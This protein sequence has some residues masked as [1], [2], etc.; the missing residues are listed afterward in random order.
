VA[1]RSIEAP[2]PIDVFSPAV[3]RPR[4]F[5]PWRRIALMGSI[6]VAIALASCLLVERFLERRDTLRLFAHETYGAVGGR[7][8]RFRLLGAGEPG[9]T[10]V[11][12]PGLFA[13]IEQW[14]EAQ[15]TLASF[16]PTLSYDRGGM[17]HSDPAPA[18]DA[19]GEAEELEGVLRTSGAAPPYLIVSYSSSVLAAQVFAARHPEFIK[20]LVF[21]DPMFNEGASPVPYA[22]I[23]GKN[24]I[25]MTLK[26]A[27]GYLRFQQFLENRSAPPPTLVEEKERAILASTANW[28]S[29][30]HEAFSLDR[31]VKEAKAAPPLTSVPVGVLSAM[32]PTEEVMALDIQA[33]RALAEKAVWGTFRTV[34]HVNHSKVLID[35][36]GLEGVLSLIREVEDQV[37]QGLA[38]APGRTV[39]TGG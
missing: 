38:T 20:G 21:I 16:A 25:V 31:S 19:A 34:S 10:I 4:W 22:R 11:L 35:R 36:T 15:N 13:Y 27:F 39:P 33:Q 3:R 32:D 23:L 8:V 14:D 17:G 37:R 26:A 6:A 28:L 30:V 7:N 29:F 1:Q 12:V 18:H 24:S 5:K 9:P 2:K